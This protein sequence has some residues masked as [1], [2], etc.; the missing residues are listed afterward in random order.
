MFGSAADHHPISAIHAAG[1]PPQSDLPA[2]ESFPSRAASLL[3]GQNV[4]VD[5]GGLTQAVLE[6]ATYFKHEKNI[7][8]V[9][10]EICSQVAPY[11]GFNDSKRVDLIQ[12]TDNL[13]H[14]NL[15]VK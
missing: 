15:S 12:V 4:F 5:D 7:L 9:L 1:Q 13:E 8:F 14:S 2:G 11:K 6:K 3:R 10:D